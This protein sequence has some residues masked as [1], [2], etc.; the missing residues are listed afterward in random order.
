MK[1]VES[2]IDDD[3]DV[4]RRKQLATVALY[5]L[6]NARIK[7]KRLKTSTKIKLNKS[8]VKPIILLYN[9]GTWTLTQTEEESLNAYHRKQLNKILRLDTQRKSQI[10]RFKDA[11]K[12]NHCHYKSYL[13]KVKYKK[14]DF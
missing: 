9:Y 3:K 11:A 10:H 4:E 12:K 6:N 5:K 8:L 13:V 2:L 1:K 14:K 7:S